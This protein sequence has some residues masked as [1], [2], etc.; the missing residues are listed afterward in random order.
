MYDYK[1]I[2]EEY[3]ALKKRAIQAAF[4]AIHAAFDSHHEEQSF[5]GILVAEIVT[6]F[7]YW[8]AIKKQ[9]NKNVE[10]TL[11]E[12]R[13]ISNYKFDNDG[14]ADRAPKNTLYEYDKKAN[15][16]YPI[17]VENLAYYD[18][19]TCD[20]EFF[21][22]QLEGK[23]GNLR[24]IDVEPKQTR[25]DDYDR[26]QAREDNEELEERQREMYG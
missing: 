16:F 2:E 5:N 10:C 7:S 3:T 13:T 12:I 6:A 21:V 14:E 23:T 8:R 26:E 1:A 25:F 4:D 11:N 20:L 18:L 24:F 15:E 9:M 19:S 22:R 17:T